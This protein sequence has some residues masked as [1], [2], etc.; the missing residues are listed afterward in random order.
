MV[1]ND[2]HKLESQIVISVFQFNYYRPQRSWGKIIFSEAC[3]RNSVHGGVSARLHAGIHTPLGPEADTPLGP[4]ADTRP[5]PRSRFPPYPEQTSIRNRPPGTVHPGRYGQQAGGMHPTGMHTCLWNQFQSFHS[6][7]Y[8]KVK[9]TIGGSK[10]GARDAPP[11]PGGPNSFIFMQFSGKKLKNNSTFGSWRTP[12]GKILDPPLETLFS[13]T[14][15]L[16]L[17]L[18]SEVFC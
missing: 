13:V 3:V 8:K 9:E 4:E 12:L 16:F 1:E 15:T 6:F 10:G 18:Q 2:G 7:F 5:D 17:V 11:P 14:L